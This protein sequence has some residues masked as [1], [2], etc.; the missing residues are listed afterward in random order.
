LGATKGRIVRQLITESLMLSLAAGCLGLALAAGTVRALVAFGPSDVPRLAEA[1]IDPVVLLWTLALC[2]S[3]GVAFGI[4]PAFIA[5]R[6]SHESLKRRSQRAPAFLMVAELGLA[7]VLLT[8]AAL[9]IRSFLA[10]EAA[11]PGFRPE[12]V[13]TMNVY[14]SGTPARNIELEQSVL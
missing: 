4:V 9:L 1:S 5:H 2:L 3:T 10:V 12:G 11:D 13:L 6:N 14:V 7:M 8:G